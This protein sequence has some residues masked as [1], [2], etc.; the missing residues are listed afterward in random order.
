MARYSTDARA[1]FGD[2]RE[3]PRASQI[4]MPVFFGQADACLASSNSF[5]TMADLNP[6]IGLRLRV[7]EK[8]PGFTTG[9][10]AV[11]KNG[12]T[13]RREEMIRALA[14]MDGDPKGKQLLTL[15]RVNRLVPFHA[16]HLTSVEKMLRAH[17]S[18][19]GSRK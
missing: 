1:F 19:T 12:R 7:L 5:E 4:I 16:E 18:Y 2:L 13:P 14:E 6:Q 9:I 17:R 11:R 8:S 3:F 10:I 15:F